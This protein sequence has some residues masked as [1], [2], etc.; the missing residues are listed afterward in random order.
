MK[1]SAVIIR[2]LNRNDA[3]FFS[4]KLGLTGSLKEVRQQGTW[5]ASPLRYVLDPGSRLAEP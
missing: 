4:G 2:Q 5:R 1:D 3:W